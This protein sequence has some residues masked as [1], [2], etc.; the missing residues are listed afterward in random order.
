MRHG[1]VAAQ[2]AVPIVGFRVNSALGQSAVQNLQPFLSLAAA[3]DLADSGSEHIHRRNRLAA[4]VKAHVEGLDALGIVGHDDRAA[5]VIFGQVALV[6][7]LQVGTPRD[8]ELEPSLGVLQG[9]Y[10]LGVGHSLERLVDHGSQ[11]LDRVAVD[12][13]FEE[14]HVVGALF[15]H[16]SEQVL[17]QRFG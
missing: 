13:L 3:H 15:Q 6:L 8:I 14:F 5:H 10:G 12:S 16:G 17:E 2:V 7:G 9:A 4:I 11:A 1:A